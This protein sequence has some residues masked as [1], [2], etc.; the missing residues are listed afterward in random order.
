MTGVRYKRRIRLTLPSPKGEGSKKKR[1][2]KVLS[3]GEDIGEANAMPE[4]KTI[5]TS[6]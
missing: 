3:F 5:S 4:L 1:E 2:A 6:R